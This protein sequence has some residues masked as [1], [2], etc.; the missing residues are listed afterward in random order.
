MA[1]VTGLR[2][3]PPR[4]GKSRPAGFTLLEL[5]IVMFIIGMMSGLAMLTVGFGN[6]DQSLENEARRLRRL[7]GL[8][9]QEAI[10]QGREI[11]ILITRDAYRFLTPGKLGWAAMDA[12]DMLRERELPQGWRLEL[13]QDEQ[14]ADLAAAPPGGEGETEEGKPPPPQ[15]LFYATGEV[16]PFRLSLH[17]Q[18]D[19]GFY[20]IEAQA[21]GEIEMSHRGLAP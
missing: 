13:V 10:L 4:P 1:P 8:T 7:M 20:V 16:T 6:P 15:I 5:L 11:G 9:A 18:D 14:P 3:S 21:N 12:D 19:S 17:S 2:L